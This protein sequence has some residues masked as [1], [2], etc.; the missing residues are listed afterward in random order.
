MQFFTD[1]Q[2]IHFLS[3][4]AL[5]KKHHKNSC[6]DEKQI[7]RAICLIKYYALFAIC[8]IFSTEQQNCYNFSWNFLCYL[9]ELTYLQTVTGAIFT[10][11]SIISL[12]SS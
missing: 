6:N 12:A 11:L 4:S 5:S 10:S 1:T 2:T 8:L 7:C 9:N 3:R